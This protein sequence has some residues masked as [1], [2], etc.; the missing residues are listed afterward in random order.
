LWYGD[1]IIEVDGISVSKNVQFLLENSKQANIRF[2]RN[3]VEFE[4][5][6]HFDPERPTIQKAE[7]SWPN[8]P[9]ALFKS[10]IGQRFK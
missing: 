3:K 6:I 10:W 5:E 9:N 2:V 8:D 7:I 1:E 4:T